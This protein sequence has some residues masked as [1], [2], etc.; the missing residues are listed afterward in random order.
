MKKLTLKFSDGD[1]ICNEKLIKPYEVDI[2]LPEL[3]LAFEFNGLYWHSDL[4]KSR[5][6]HFNKHKMCFDL[7]VELFQI[8]EDDWL[9]KNE[10]IKSMIRNKIGLSENKIWARSCDVRVVDYKSSKV[11]LDKNHLQGNSKSKINIGLY[12][13]NELVSLMCFGR[14]RKSLGS[15]SDQTNYELYRFCNKLNTSVVGGASKILKYFIKNYKFSKLI[16]YYDK[17]FGFKSFYSLI[18]FEFSGE[19]PI[20]Y[21]YVKS[22]IRLHRYNYRK[23]ELVKMGYD[24]LLTENEITK[25]MGL[26]RIYGV[27]NYKFILKSVE[28]L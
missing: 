28:N 23:S 14:T 21:H 12:N 11:F 22:G 10:I 1:I 26:I 19:T 15:S 18:G 9:Y 27:G 6:Y 8:W 7:G 24:K 5:D 25:S 3:K 13:N 20:N 17:S 16:S 4:Y 2:Y